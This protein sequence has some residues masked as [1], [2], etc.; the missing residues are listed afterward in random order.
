MSVIASYIH[1]IGVIKDLP[2]KNASESL[3]GQGFQSLTCFDQI[4]LTR[5]QALLQEMV[6]EFLCVT[7]NVLKQDMLGVFC[8]HLPH[9]D[10]YVLIVGYTGLWQ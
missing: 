9:T 8:P 1:C 10:N 3:I 6:R 7:S 4:S 2:L 5:L